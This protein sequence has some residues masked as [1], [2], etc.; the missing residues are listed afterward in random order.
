MG[1]MQG[2]DS[3]TFETALSFFGDSVGALLIA[4]QDHNQYKALVKRGMFQDFLDESGKY[5]DLVQKLWFHFNGS[6]KAITEDYRVF[7]PNLSKFVG[8]YSQRLNLLI[9]G[10]PHIVQMMI[11][12]VGNEGLYLFI[13]DELQQHEYEDD[14]ETHKKVS[15]IQNTYL[16]SMCF[17]LV[18]NTTSSLSLTEVSSET[19]NSQ[20]SYTDW[21]LMISNMFKKK[22]RKTFLKRSDPEY[23]RT[24]FEPGQIDSFDLMM[25]NLEGVYIWVKLIFGR[26]ETTNE[27]DY[28][29]VYMVQNIHESTVQVRESLRRYEELASLDPLTQIYNHGRIETEIC[30]AIKKSRKNGTELSMLMLDI[31]FFKNVNDRYGHAAGDSTLVRFTELIRDT[32]KNRKAAYGRWGGEEFAVVL[33]DTGREEVEALAEKIRSRV[34]NESFPGTGSVTCS[35]GAG[36]LQS[37]DDFDSFFGRVDRAVYTAK[38]N[39]RNCVCLK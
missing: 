38:E 10:V 32:F 12:P 19:M 34:E 35:I 17:D 15:T 22:D 23:L 30:N 21:R 37:D 4:D 33:Y 27:E 1:V 26:M 6:D 7:I 5:Q 24:H 13:L 36:V 28:R 8:K 31:D 11:R 14:V 29:F 20:I 9:D 25:Q 18:K 39:G 16:F 2:I 3:V